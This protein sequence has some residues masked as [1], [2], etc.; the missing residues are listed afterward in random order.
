MAHDLGQVVVGVEVIFLNAFTLCQDRAAADAVS[1]PFG[2]GSAGRVQ[3]LKAH[4]VG[5]AGQLPGRVPD[6]LNRE[7]RKGGL[8]GPVGHV[9][10]A[11]GRQ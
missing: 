6:N 10:F 2:C 8:N 4:P 1:L 5:V 3:S 11:G 9:T 7:G